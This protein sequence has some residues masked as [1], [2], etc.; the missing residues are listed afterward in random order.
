[1]STPATPRFPLDLRIDRT[2]GGYRL[3]GHALTVGRI[4][5]ASL[6]EL[7]EKLGDALEDAEDLEALR[8]ARQD[9]EANGTVPWEQVKADLG[10]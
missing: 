6:R 2:D 1:M 5:A 8:L 9:A 3:E 7:V 4:E 10:L